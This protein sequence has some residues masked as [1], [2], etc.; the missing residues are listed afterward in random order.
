ME[1]KK[2]ITV[3]LLKAG[4]SSRTGLDYTEAVKTFNFGRLLKRGLLRGEHQMPHVTLPIKATRETNTI[5]REDK[6]ARVKHS[7]NGVL[8]HQVARI[9]QIHEDNVSHYIT[10]IRVED[11]VVK[12]DAT[13]CGPYAKLF[14]RLLEINSLHFGMRGFVER[15]GMIVTRIHE[16]V[17]FDLVSTP[18]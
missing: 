14:E 13:P 17:T 2:F 5:V 3:E 10:N 8:H 15:D 9:M 1:E 6:H 16:I 18:L 4:V 11:G 12:G 7:N